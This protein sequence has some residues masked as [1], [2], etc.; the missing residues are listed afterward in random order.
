MN[1]R[2]NFISALVYQAVHIV[3][4]LILPRL[5]ISY[6]GSDVNGLISSIT[7]FLSFISLLE[8][9]LGAVV[10]AELYRPI[11][12]N[13]LEKIHS[14]IYS[15]KKLF[16]QLAIVYL[17]YTIA[18][19]IIYP[20]LIS[21]EFSFE[22]ISTLTLVLSITTLSQYLFAIS[23][24]LLLQATQKIYIVNYISSATLVINIL[25]FVVLL[26]VFP[27]MHIIKLC[28]GLVFLLQP[29]LYNHFVAPQYREVEN[30]E[31]NYKLKNRW[32]GFAQN[33]AY[34]ININ[35][36]IAVVT[37]FL[38]IKNVSVYSIYMLGI[39]ALRQVITN[40]EVSYQSALGKY[41][42]MDN[43][44]N[45]E[46]KFKRF[47]EAFW[48]ISIVLFCACLQLINSFVSIY[49]KGVNDVEY[50]QPV[51]AIIM[52][53]A[54]MVYCIREP[55]KILIYSA[56]KFKETNTGSYIEAIL[57][58]LLSLILVSRFG[59]V[60]IAVG[61]FV[62]ILYRLIY[63]IVFLQSALFSH[64]IVRRFIKLS[65][66]MVI[67][68]SINIFFY[69]NH[70]LY[71]DS[72]IHFGIVGL[73]VVFVEIAIVLIVHCSVGI[74]GKHINRKKQTV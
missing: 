60:G 44:D 49:T 72:I 50:Y 6:F 56:G 22:Y 55:Y 10:L 34:F 57:N 28:S 18:I 15:C 16:R 9:G 38:G 1:N 20:L 4:G 65:I 59:L 29:L 21:H 30:C 71:I 46:R 37:I 8:G 53:L 36:D 45:L 7:Q 68:C 32:S 41:Y 73:I 3:Q 69:M 64:A 14:I 17:L 13:D 2:K 12:N 66:E 11:E 35:T 67:I 42:A 74:I 5:I 39:N 62:A 23:N 48:G 19:A 26:Y 25:I 51:F 40:A 58:L 33:L 63:F 43:K 61:T 31:K 24:K 54:N 52:V 70:T 27:K 47:E